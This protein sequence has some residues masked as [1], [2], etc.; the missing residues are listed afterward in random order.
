MIRPRLLL[1]SLPAAALA[2]LYVPTQALLVNRA[3][4][5]EVDLK[6]NG[7]IAHIR[8]TGFDVGVQVDL[9]RLSDQEKFRLSLDPR[10]PSP[11]RAGRTSRGTDVVFQQ[12]PP[13]TYVATR[14]ALGTNDPVPFKPDTLVVRVGQILSLGRVRVSPQLDMLGLMEKLEVQT[15]VWVIDSSIKAVRAYG[16]DTLPVV[17]KRIRW[18]IEAK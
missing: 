9:A 13:G 14:I 7:L 18:T 11:P 3:K 15:R 1:L 16:I 5:S 17:S 12:L 8:D 6:T 10:P 4:P 2:G